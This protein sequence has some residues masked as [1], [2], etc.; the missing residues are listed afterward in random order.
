M[1]CESESGCVSGSAP[2]FEPGRG[3]GVD[4]VNG[5]YG[6]SDGVLAANMLAAAMVDGRA[7]QW[8]KRKR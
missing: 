2:D 6:L 7:P 1:C 5:R 3:S 8:T 4:S